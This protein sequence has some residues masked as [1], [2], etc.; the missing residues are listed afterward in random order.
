MTPASREHSCWIRRRGGR[1]CRSVPRGRAA[2]F[3]FA[4]TSSRDVLRSAWHLDCEGLRVAVESARATRRRTRRPREPPDEPTA[5]PAAHPRGD[6][7]PRVA[8]RKRR[9]R[10]SR[11]SS[12]CIQQRFETDVCSVYLLEPDRSNLVLAATVGL[13]PESVG[14][15]RM[16]LDEGLA[17]LVAEQLRPQVVEDATAHPRFKYFRE[18]GEDPYHSLSRRAADRSRAAAGRARAC[19]RSSRACSATTWRGC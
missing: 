5:I 10:R 18:A 8:Q 11:T 12:S 17:G 9:R 7:P 1:I 2:I 6:Q 16:R 4:P 13:R 14:R 3:D 19:R 15:I